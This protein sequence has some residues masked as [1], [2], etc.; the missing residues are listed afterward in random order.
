MRLTVLCSGP[1]NVFTQGK[2]SVIAVLKQVSAI[3]G[4]HEL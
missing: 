4:F 2:F 1:L 3:L